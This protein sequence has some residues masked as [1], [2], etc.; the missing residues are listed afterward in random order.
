[1]STATFEQRRTGDALTSLAAWG[2]IAGGQLIVVGGIPLAS[3][4]AQNPPP[5]AIPVLNIIIHL[6][7]MA[8]VVGLLRSEAAGRGRLAVAGPALTL[9]GF[10]VLVPAEAAWLTQLGVADTLFSVATLALML[11]LLL[12]GA[13]VVRARRWTGW[14]R[15]TP[16]ACGLFIPLV[17]YPSFGL[18]GLAMHY[19]LGLWGVCWL[20]L[21]LALRAEA[22]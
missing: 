12:A 20:L 3:F 18:P 4:Q 8:G 15:F 7:Q 19:A 17:L 21:G 22:G 2:L 5:A 14:H 6:L 9:F 1:M 10:A 16:L 13:A 11:G